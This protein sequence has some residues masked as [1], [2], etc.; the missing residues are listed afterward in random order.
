MTQPV[1]GRI[2]VTDHLPV[3]HAD[4]IGIG[5]PV[6]V[7]MSVAQQVFQTVEQAAGIVQIASRQ[8][9]LYQQCQTL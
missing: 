3:N 4:L 5:D 8:R 1:G 7:I 2:F 6:A 9:T